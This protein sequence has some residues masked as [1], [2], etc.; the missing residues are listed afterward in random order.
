[1]KQKILLDVPIKRWNLIF[2]GRVGELPIQLIS[3]LFVNIVM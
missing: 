2:E 3:N 1:M